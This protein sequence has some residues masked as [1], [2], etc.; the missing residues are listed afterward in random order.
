MEILK[1]R[2]LCENNII[3]KVEIEKQKSVYMSAVSRDYFV[4]FVDRYRF[5]DVWFKSAQAD[6]FPLARGGKSVWMKDYKYHWAED[7]FRH[8]IS[9]P[10]PLAE[11][12]F[13][14]RHY[15][16]V[17]FQNG[18]TRTLY[19]LCNGAK[20]FPVSIYNEEYAKQAHKHIGVID[21]PILKLEDFEAYFKGSDRFIL[22]L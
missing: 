18:I 22:S 12:V 7:G 14:S 21:S 13:N 2:I 5:E 4:V 1:K 6:E 3:F 20:V 8:G 9:N 10:V 15:P 11:I 16:S 19:L 17:G